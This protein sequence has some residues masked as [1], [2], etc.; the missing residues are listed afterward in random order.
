MYLVF[1][2]IR[3]RCRSGLVGHGVVATAA[4]GVAAQ[5]AA[6]GQIESAQ[7]AVLLY[8]LDGVLA[9]GGGEAAGGGR[10]RRYV[11]LIEADGSD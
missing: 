2:I 8:G 4:P 6:H 5:D 3:R 9:A 11:A 10:Q 7:G 1:F